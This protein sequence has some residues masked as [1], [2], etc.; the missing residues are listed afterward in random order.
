MCTDY[1]CAAP[2]CSEA[3]NPPTRL[4]PVLYIR[5]S[6]AYGRVMG[7]GIPHYKGLHEGDLTRTNF[8]HEYDS[9]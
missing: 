9:P 8:P 5:A 7:G 3:I 6:E 2:R 1:Q 4:P